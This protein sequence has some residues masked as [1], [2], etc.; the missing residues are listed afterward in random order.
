MLHTRR[1]HGLS[2]H[3]AFI[4]F[5]KAHGTAN[6]WSSPKICSVIEHL[7]RSQSSVQIGRHYCQNQARSRS[8]P[9][10]QHGASFV[11]IFDGCI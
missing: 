11:S 6:L 1:N 7:Y 4:D 5:V 3:V 2:T 10:R 8:T 9:K